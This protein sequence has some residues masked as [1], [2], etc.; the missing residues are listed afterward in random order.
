VTIAGRFQAALVDIEE[1]TLAGPELLPV[2]L[3]LATA[4]TLR[5]DA[6][7]IGIADAAAHPVPLGASS[8]DAAHAERLQFTVGEGP[9]TTAQQTGQPVFALETDL[10]RRWPGF[11]DLLLGDTP[12]RAVVALPL[13]VAHSGAGALDLFFQR[14]DQVT[15]LDVFE[16]LAVGQLITSMLDDAAVSPESPASGPEWLHGPASRQR[17]AVWEALGRVGID[18]DIDAPSALMLLRAR[19]YGSNR[20]VDDVA[21]DLLAGRLRTEELRPDGQYS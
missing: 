7:S 1:P 9:C 19:A 13:Q 10:R 3:A 18:L 6:A 11:S 17:T 4:R 14:S 12:F 16:A 5:V 15:G 8:D 2:R 21:A 20:A